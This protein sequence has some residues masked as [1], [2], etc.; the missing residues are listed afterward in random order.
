M[1]VFQMCRPAGPEQN[2]GRRGRRRSQSCQSIGQGNFDA[3]GPFAQTQFSPFAGRSTA[4]GRSE[5][6]EKQRRNDD[7]D[8]V[9]SMAIELVGPG[10]SVCR[11]AG[12]T[13]PVDDCLMADRI[14][15]AHGGMRPMGMALSL[16]VCAVPT[17]GRTAGA[18]PA[19]ARRAQPS[20]P[21]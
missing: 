12:L 9:N 8:Q 4:A 7:V 16:G 14:E 17:W 2:V 5:Q 21:R 1:H 11:L 19:K 6:V 10:L 15:I 3:I 18:W 13:Q 20:C